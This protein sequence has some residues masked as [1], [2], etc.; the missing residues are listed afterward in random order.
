MCLT[1]TDLKEFIV[2]YNRFHFSK[3][4]FLIAIK[5][6]SILLKLFYKIK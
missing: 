3:K 6:V 2:I 4:M 1:D 5:T